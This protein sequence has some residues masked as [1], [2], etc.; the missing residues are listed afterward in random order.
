M[1]SAKAQKGPGLPD[2]V[3]KCRAAALAVVEASKHARVYADEASRLAK[4]AKRLQPLLDD[5][6]D[7]AVAPTAE[8]QGVRAL[9]VRHGWHSWVW[10]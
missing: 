10:M 3:H 5:L 6:E 9:Q 4:F 7:N 1:R 2:A 8:E